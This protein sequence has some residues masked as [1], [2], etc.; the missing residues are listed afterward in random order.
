MLFARIYVDSE[1]GKNTTPHY[2]ELNTRMSMAL[3]PL[4][5]LLIGIPFGIRARRS[6]TSVGLL[7]CVVL[8]VFFYAF[9]LLSD[10]LEKQSHLHPE[11]L[12]WLP[13]IF[14]QLGGLWAL[15]VIGRH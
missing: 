10:S 2:V 12:V 9:I 15:A 7:I 8:A 3:A 11:L 6:Q 1:A 13:N 5:F 4:A 14:Y